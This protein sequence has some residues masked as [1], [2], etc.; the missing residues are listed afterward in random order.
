M[1]STDLSEG[2]PE[3]EIPTPLKLDVQVDSPQEC[4]RH[5][6]V[7][8][9]HE[10]VERYLQKEFDTLV[11]EAQVPGFRPGRAPRRLVEKQFRDRVEERVKSA[12]LMDSLSQVTEEASFSAISEPDFDFESIELPADTDFRFEFSV[13]VRPEFETPSHE[14]LKLTRKVE[15]ITEDDVTN[16]LNGLLRRY[17]RYEPTDQPANET[18]RLLITATFKDGDTVISTMDEERVDM[19]SALSFPD[20]TFENFSEVIMGISEGETRTGKV[21]VAEGAE[22]EEL[23]GKEVDAEITAVEVTNYFAPELTPKFLDELGAFESVEELRAF[24]RSSLERQANYR[25]QQDLRE[26]LTQ[27]LIESVNFELPKELV[28]RQVQRE[29]E[30]RVL[31]MRSSG[32]DENMIRQFVNTLRQNAQKS[33]EQ[34]LREHFILEQIAEEKTIEAEES[35]FVEEIARI[36]EQRGEPVR[37]VRARLEKSGGM[38]SLRNQI[39]ERKVVDMIVEAADVTE[40]KVETPEN[41]NADKMSAQAAVQHY[42]AGE[43]EE[44]IP[45]AKYD[46]DADQANEGKPTA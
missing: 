45:E 5:V 37:R 14:N 41:E 11:P 44:E 42:V 43:P 36:A 21:K 40:E 46:N 13:E 6:V 18:S 39:V 23:R 22:Q 9:P 7:T 35:D 30:R 34:S 16:A 10:E 28:K 8:I 12:L 29:V 31:E 4:L 26:Q 1:S 33:T 38:D 15:E 25:Q 20:A 19:A 27:K 24:V 3:A 2:T 32:F 17:G